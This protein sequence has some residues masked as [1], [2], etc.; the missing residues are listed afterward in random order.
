[1][2]G[3]K[4]GLFKRESNVVNTN[5]NIEKGEMEGLLFLFLEFD[6]DY[7]RNQWKYDC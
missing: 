1:M 7:C 2:A 4:D 6:E 5:R 3:Y